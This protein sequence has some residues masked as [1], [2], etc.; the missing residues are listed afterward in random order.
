MHAAMLYQNNRAARTLSKYHP[1]VNM[2]DDLGYTPLTWLLLN[3]FMV[4]YQWEPKD[5]W[6]SKMKRDIELVDILLASGADPNVCT[7]DGTTSLHLVAAVVP[8]HGKFRWLRNSLQKE[9]RSMFAMRRAK[10]LLPLPLSK[11]TGKNL[12]SS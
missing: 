10:P 1:D 11:K 3:H 9:P 7:K 6:P 8:G 2:K 5:D 4:R 12:C